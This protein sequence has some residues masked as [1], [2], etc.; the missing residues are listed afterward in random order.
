MACTC[1]HAHFT[2]VFLHINV[3]LAFPGKTQHIDQLNRR[4]PIK[5]WSK[6]CTKVQ[7]CEVTRLLLFWSLTGVWVKGHRDRTPQRQ[8][9]MTE[10]S[11]P[12]CTSAHDAAL[13]LTA[14]PACC[15]C[16]LLI[17]EVSSLRLAWS[18]SP[19]A[20]CTV[21]KA[22]EG[23]TILQASTVPDLCVFPP[24][25]KVSIQGNCYIITRT[26]WWYMH[27]A[28]VSFGESVCL[29]SQLPH[30]GRASKSSQSSLNGSS[31]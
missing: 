22:R 4:E 24:G 27:E 3:C 17:R 1:V 9:S 20:V 14:Q 13:G 5:D 21:N 18:P 12:V 23:L 6:N 11:T 25:G 29:L 31:Y 10:K 8:P 16:C 28:W 19:A 15:L 26:P 7:F 2:Y 30:R